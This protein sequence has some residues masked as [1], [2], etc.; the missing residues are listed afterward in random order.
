MGSNLTTAVA[1]Q[2]SSFD[3]AGRLKAQFN[4]E[5]GVTTYAYAVSSTGLVK[6]ITYTNGG[7]YKE[8]YLTDGQLAS[9]SGT[10][11]H[12]TF[13][14]YDVTEDI[15]WWNAG[16]PM[17]ISIT[18]ASS[19]QAVTNYSDY[20][21]RPLKTVYSA[22]AEPYPVSENWYNELGQ[23]AGTVDPDGVTTHYAYQYL[24]GRRE[25][26]WIGSDQLTYVGDSRITQQLVRYQSASPD[27][28]NQNVKIV[29][30][31]VWDNPAVGTG[32]L[33]SRT[34]TSND[35]RLSWEDTWGGAA[36]SR[37]RAETVY[38]GGGVRR[39]LVTAPDG[40]RTETVYHFGRLSSVTRLDTSDNPLTQTT[41]TYDPQGR[42]WR[43]T[44]ARNG[45]T[46]YSYT[47]ADQVQ[48]VRT[49][50]PGTGPG[51]QITTT[52]YDTMGRPTVVVYPDGASLTN[53][54]TLR[55]ELAQ[56][57]G[58]R[59]YPVG[60]AYDGQ[61]RLLFM[62]NWSGHTGLGGSRVTAWQYDGYRGW[63]TN[64]LDAANAG[65]GYL[66]S[67]GGTANQTDL[68][69]GHPPAALHRLRV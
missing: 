15:Y 50:V 60:Y 44:D 69:A 55:G 62:T 26:T 49:P 46:E 63:L 56:V 3:K 20:L 7:T 51:S 42:L 25:Y 27:F 31:Y 47:S 58:A 40:T 33:V 53:R 52:T 67:G 28:E 6:T 11:A 35:G 54:Y 38:D 18:R 24:T 64:K 13:F 39:V 1:L 23:L 14:D 37:T 2:R 30:T 61:G 43:V 34:A 45:T 21:G 19:T 57:A 32:K 22:A 12:P 16:N 4:L 59:T 48:T 10:A 8:I 5:N 66:Y 65:T 17:R 68:G 41:Y 36:F 29:E 9:V